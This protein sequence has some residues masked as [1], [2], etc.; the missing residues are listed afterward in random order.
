MTIRMVK[1]VNM[2]KLLSKQDKINEQGG[3]IF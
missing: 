3:N 2:V 1:V